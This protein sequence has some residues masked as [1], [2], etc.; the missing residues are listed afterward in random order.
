MKGKVIGLLKKLVPPRIVSVVEKEPIIPKIAAQALVQSKR[1]PEFLRLDQGQIL[2][3]FPEIE[4]PYG[5][6]AGLLRL[7]ELVADYWTLRFSLPFTLEPSNVSI[8]T[9][10]TEALS[11]LLRIV[12]P[13]NKIGINWIYWS[14]YKGIIQMGGGKPVVV[15]FFDPDGNLTLDKAEEVILR[16]KIKVL[17]LNFP[18]NPSGEGLA[19]EEYRAFA[20]LA[21]RLDL[22][23]LSDE[24]YAG[25]AYEGRPLS[26]LEFAPERTIV[27]GAASKEY[28]IPG[29]RVGYVLCADQEFTGSW[30]PKLVRASTSNPN[31]LGQRRLI[32]L[33]EP[34]V[35]AMKQKKEP[36][37]L[38]R[39]R[40]ALKARRDV[41]ITALNDAGIS[42]RQRR[43]MAPLGG[44]SVLA[45]L[46]EGIEDMTFAQTAL[47]KGLFSVVP[48][49]AFGAPHGL[50]IGYGVLNESQIR[51][52]VRTFKTLIEDF[53]S[54]DL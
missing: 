33:L 20:D 16:E 18:A 2:G 21:R 3:L 19:E 41:L 22:L 24:V 52:F 32:E 12:S 38:T 40:D 27:I 49:S 9:G 17:L 11:I 53:R 8:T 45:W 14:N 26:F 42:I 39:I 15:P 46:P 44:I 48:G 23:I 37:L 51:L 50:R 31:I 6:P 5:P 7:R 36:P 28:L 43:G 54:V 47:D 1:N 13:D 4:I 35:Q 30:M 29:A 10:A 34:D 25:M